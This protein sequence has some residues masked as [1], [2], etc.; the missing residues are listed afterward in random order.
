MKTAKE[1]IVRRAKIEKKRRA[2]GAEDGCRG[3][4]VSARLVGSVAMFCRTFTL[5]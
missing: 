4:C 5:V 2:E 3:C 1:V